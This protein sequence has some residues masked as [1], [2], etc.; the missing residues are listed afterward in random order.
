ME[1]YQT[2]GQKACKIQIFGAK[3]KWSTQFGRKAHKFIYL[4]QLQEEIFNFFF[5][6]IDATN[7]TREKTI[8]G[9]ILHKQWH[10]QDSVQNRHGAQ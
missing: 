5:F 6:L 10:Q 7:E 1:Q 9:R 8:N 3:S 4:F 2:E